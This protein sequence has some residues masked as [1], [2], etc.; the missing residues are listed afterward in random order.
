MVTVALPAYG[1]ASST[2]PAAQP[3]SEL[4]AVNATFTPQKDLCL[5]LCRRD[6]ALRLFVRDQHTDHAGPGAAELCAQ[7]CRRALR[8][9]TAVGDDWGGEWGV[10][11]ALA[12]HRGHKSWVVVPR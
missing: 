4:V 12:P 6:D 2:R 7:R 9:L 1:L 3:A 11:R 10:C 8:L 5:C